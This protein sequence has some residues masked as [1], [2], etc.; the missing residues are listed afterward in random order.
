MKN[1]IPQGPYNNP[2]VDDGIYEAII[3]RTSVGAY[4][5]G[6]YIQIIMRLPAEDLYFAT[7]VYFPNEHASR[8]KQRLWHLC[9]LLGLEVND[10]LTQPGL[11][12]DKRLRVQVLRM[13]R[14]TVNG[15]NPYYDVERFLETKVKEQPAPT[16]DAAPT[17]QEQKPKRRVVQQK[18]VFA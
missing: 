7:N 10:V 5:K 4:N 6:K 1:S 16:P 12:R 13:Q 17:P 18:V 15:G 3:D 8:S 14:K 2:K 9:S 11:L